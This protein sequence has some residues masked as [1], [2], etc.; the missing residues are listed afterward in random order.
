MFTAW[1]SSSSNLWSSTSLYASESPGCKVARTQCHSL[2][3]NDCLYRRCTRLRW[4]SYR[5]NLA[6]VFE[7]TIG[8]SLMLISSQW[9]TKS[10]QAP[11]FSL[12]YLGLGLAQIIG[13]ILSYA[14]QHIAHDAIAGWRVMFVVLGIVTVIVGVAT[15]FFLPDTPMKA[16]FLSRE[17]KIMLLE[18]VSVN[19]TGI[20]NKRF[21]LSQIWEACLDLQIWLLILITILVSTLSLFH[22]EY[23][24]NSLCLAI[25]L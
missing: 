6:G 1:L 16:K 17:E 21:Q 12:W 23:R 3:C 11:R 19:Q 22:W 18:H 14:F 7:A 24:L 9:Y 20:D 25:C 2:G 10:E 13:G 8:P 5:E 4:P 15:A